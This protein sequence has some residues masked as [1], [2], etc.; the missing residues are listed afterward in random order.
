VNR[1]PNEKQPGKGLHS[2]QDTQGFT[3]GEAIVGDVEQR[4]KSFNSLRARMALAGYEVHI[5]SDR[6]TGRGAYLVRRWAMHRELPDMPALIDFAKRA[7]V[8]L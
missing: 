3:S 2:D 8:T 5:I 4:D 7:G 1:P 6:A